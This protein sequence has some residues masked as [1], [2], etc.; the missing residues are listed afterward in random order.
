M[1]LGQRIVMLRGRVSQTKLAA[2]AGI[3]PSTLNRIERGANRNPSQATLRAI[4]KGL[5][6]VGVKCELAELLSENS[7]VIMTRNAADAPRISLESLRGAS[8]LPDGD[9]ADIL[10]TLRE[11]IRDA[12]VIARDARAR[13]DEALRLVSHRGRRSA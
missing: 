10:Y 3:D 1:D 2:K 12:V 6:Q 13:A 11:E 9:L 4:L 8:D 7:G 5:K